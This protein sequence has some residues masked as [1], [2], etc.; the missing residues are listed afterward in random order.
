MLTNRLWILGKTCLVIVASLAGAAQ[1]A[2]SRESYRFVNGYWFDGSDFTKREVLVVGNVIVED[3]GE[4][5]PRIVDLA[6]GYVLPGYGNAHTHAIG[7]DDFQAESSRFLERGV[8]YVANPNSIGA[9]GASAR[10]ALKTPTTVDAVLANGGLTSTGGHPTQIFESSAANDTM[11]GNAYFAIDNLE[12]LESRWAEILAG[13]PDFVK[14]YLERSEQHAT[15][16][17]DPSYY[18]RRGLDPALVSPIVEK[19]HAAGLRV[20][21]HVTS[22]QDFRVAVEAGVDEIAHLPLEKLEADDARLAAKNEVVVVTT[23]LSH[24][25]APGVED[26]DE[27]HRH[28]LAALRA[29]GVRLALGTDSQA[30]VVDEVVKL[31]SLDVFPRGELLRLLTID[32][33][34]WIFPDRSLGAPAVGSEASFV[35][36]ETSPLEDLGA[37]KR[38]SARY[39]AGMAIEIQETTER[40]AGI[41]QTLVHTIMSRGVEAA[42]AEYH[43]LRKEESDEYDFGEGQLDALG[44]ALMQHGK[45]AEAIAI[46][47]LNAEQFPDSEEARAKL[48]EVR[49]KQDP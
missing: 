44:D 36:L 37:L 46:Y 30:S 39:K 7:N 4:T 22:R 40:K 11:E 38:I 29:A 10:E 6:G 12:Q 13:K 5:E 34:G 28:N 48:D 14:I 20:A 24:R 27:L 23:A 8:F 16:K 26:L 49:K 2:V 45:R 18:G 15:R 25:P 3:T 33:P 41:G 35:V 47:Q 32:T 1:V 31:A 17:D 9:R 42:I 43:R 21:A 19:A